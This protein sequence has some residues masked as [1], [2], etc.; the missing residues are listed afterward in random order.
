[1]PY[2]LN[3]LKTGAITIIAIA[4]FPSVIQNLIIYFTQRKKFNLKFK[5]F[6]PI[7]LASP[8]YGLIYTMSI[9]LGIISK[10]KWKEIKRTSMQ[11]LNNQ[12]SKIKEKNLQKST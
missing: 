5:T 1:M 4:I 8:I 2:C 6:I 7:I 9:S 11:D 3:M 10:S 12:K